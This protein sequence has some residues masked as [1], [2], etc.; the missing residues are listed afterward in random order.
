MILFKPDMK[1]AIIERRKTVTRRQGKK[2][3]NVGAEHLCYTRPA[4]CNPPGKP[5]ARVRIVSVTA[6]SLPGSSLLDNGLKAFHDDG[7]RE[8]FS[9][10]FAFRDGYLRINGEHAWAQPCWRVAFELVEVLEAGCEGGCAYDE[11]ESR[12]AC[13][14]CGRNFADAGDRRRCF[15]CCDTTYSC[16]SEECDWCP[17]S[18]ECGRDYMERHG[19]ALDAG[20]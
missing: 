6:E 8:G 2:R 15:L 5:F 7:R 17:A 4:F 9:D 20:S 19:P 11:E 12:D 13:E 3:W 18:D 1:Q 10:W 14:G 16:G